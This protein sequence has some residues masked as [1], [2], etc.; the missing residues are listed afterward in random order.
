MRKAQYSYV[1]TIYIFAT[2]PL[3]YQ[4]PLGWLL[5]A[6]LAFESIRSCSDIYVYEWGI[7]AKSLISTRTFL[8]QDLRKFTY[9]YPNL[10]IYSNSKIAFLIPTLAVFRWQ[11]NAGALIEILEQHVRKTL[12]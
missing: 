12:L 1:P 4:T 11:K 8:W 3:F 5:W 9:S 2:I 6:I 7:Q 10:H